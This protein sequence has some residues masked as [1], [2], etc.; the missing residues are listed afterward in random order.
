MEEC[1]RLFCETL[2]AV[3]LGEGN[4]A[5]QDSLVMGTHTSAGRVVMLRPGSPGQCPPTP[6]SAG[7]AAKASVGQWMEMWDYVGGL[8]FRGFVTAEHR[9]HSMFVF[10]DESLVGCDLKP[11]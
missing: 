6:D 11:G 9:D 8:R 4:L 3:F 10:F 2:R 5:R 1:E 7:A